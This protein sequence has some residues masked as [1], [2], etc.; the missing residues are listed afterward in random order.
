MRIFSNL[1]QGIMKTVEIISYSRAANE[2]TRQG[3]HDIAKKLMLEL[4]AV[5][6]RS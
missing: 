5:R 6:E 4:A 1:W 3:H 2:L